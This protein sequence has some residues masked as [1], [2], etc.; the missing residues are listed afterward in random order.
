MT[1]RWSGSESPARRSPSRRSHARNSTTSGERDIELRLVFRNGLCDC[2]QLSALV[3]LHR[4]RVGKLADEVAVAGAA[5][6]EEMPL[7]RPH[8]DEL[9]G[10]QRPRLACRIADRLRARQKSGVCLDEGKRPGGSVAAEALATG[11]RVILGEAREEDERAPVDVNELRTFDLGELA[12][13][14]DGRPDLPADEVVGTRMRDDAGG[15]GAAFGRPRRDQDL[16][17]VVTR[18]DVEPRVAPRLVAPAGEIEQ[19]VPAAVRFDDG[20]LR[21]LRPADEIVGRREA[22]P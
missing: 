10:I 5:E 15:V 12:R 21:M 1:T 7:P 17:P 4:D 8:P 14:G 13:V 16:D 19:L 11:R 22:D 20:V 9:P 6:A 18:I 3:D 2:P